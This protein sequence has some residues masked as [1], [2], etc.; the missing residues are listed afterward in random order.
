[1]QNTIVAL[2]NE[3]RDQVSKLTGMQ[4]LRACASWRPDSLNYR[5]PVVATKIASKL[6]ARRTLDLNDEVADRDRL[7]EPLVEELGSTLIPHL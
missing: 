7:I 6:L 5:G 2:P 1:M 4:L 3:V